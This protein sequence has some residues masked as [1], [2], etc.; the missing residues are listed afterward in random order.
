MEKIHHNRHQ[1]YEVLN[2]NACIIFIILQVWLWKCAKLLNGITGSKQWLFYLIERESVN[3]SSSMQQMQLHTDQGSN[4]VSKLFH[5]LC[6]L[7]GIDKTRTTALHPQSDGMVERYNSTME[8]MLATCVT[9][10][11]RTGTLCYHYKWW[12]IE[13]QNITK[14]NIH[15]IWWCS[16]VMRD[17]P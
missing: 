16:G 6:N 3:S 11:Q 17:N 12:R 2:V 10:D 7:L 13:V 14:Q 8:A 1:M 4:F 5:E 9:K 15:R